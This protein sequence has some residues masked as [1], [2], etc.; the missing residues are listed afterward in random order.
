METNLEL[1]E[2]PNEAPSLASEMHMACQQ[3]YLDC[4]G[5]I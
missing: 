4:E 2:F 1:S 5:Q 3:P